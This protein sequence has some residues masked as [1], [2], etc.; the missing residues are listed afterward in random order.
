MRQG[1]RAAG[2]AHA[3]VSP[4]YKCRCATKVAKICC[5]R[6]I[7]RELQMTLS[8]LELPAFVPVLNQAEV[9]ER[10]AVRKITRD[11]ELVL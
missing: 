11:V 5:S 4:S 9:C 3:T 2:P 7:H 10:S 1:P 6:A 8:F